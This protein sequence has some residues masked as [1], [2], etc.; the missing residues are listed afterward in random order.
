M[1]MSRFSTLTFG[2]ITIWWLSLALLVDSTIVH[3]CLGVRCP[4]GHRCVSSPKACFV[5]PCPQYDCISTLPSEDLNCQGL[6]LYTTNKFSVK[7]G[8]RGGT[9]NKRK[10][11]EQRSGPNADV[12]VTARLNW[13]IP[14]ADPFLE[15]ERGADLA[16]VPDSHRCPS[17]ESGCVAASPCV[18]FDGER[19]RSDLAKLGEAILTRFSGRV[20]LRAILAVYY[21]ADDWETEVRI[22]LSP[23]HHPY[24]IP[25]VAKLC[26]TTPCGVAGLGSGRHGYKEN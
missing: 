3:D 22:L 17:H 26:V 12:P 11:G 7:G 5:A 21:P 10:G 1:R 13:N 16:H 15:L 9:W 6:L 20:V 18:L 14:G 25:G 2:M 24:R 19:S 8:R 4:F 23:N